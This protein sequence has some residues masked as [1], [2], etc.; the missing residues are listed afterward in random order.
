MLR[1]SFGLALTSIEDNSASRSFSARQ[2]HDGITACLSL[3]SDR[4]M[5]FSGATSARCAKL[6]RCK[7]SKQFR[8][9]GLLLL[10]YYALSIVSVGAA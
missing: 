6:P 8:M 7:V 4:A 9:S 5:R 1:I 2:S 10:A 3:A